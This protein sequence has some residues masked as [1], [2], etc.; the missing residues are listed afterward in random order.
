MSPENTRLPKQTADKIPSFQTPEEAAARDTLAEEAQLPMET[1]ENTPEHPSTTP[2]NRPVNMDS[3]FFGL[4]WPLGKKEWAIIIVIVCILA[5]TG[6]IL[7][8][9]SHSPQL[10][11]KHM[12]TKPIVSD[13]VASPLTGLPVPPAQAKLPITAVMIENSV[14][15]R[16][17]SGL[18]QAGV[19]FEALTEGGIT[20]FMALYQGNQSG[21]I[22]PV[23]S[24]RPYFID[25]LLP[26]NAAYAHVGG[27]QAAL[28]DISSLNVRDMN[29]FYNASYYTRISSR[30]APHNVYTSLN[31]LSSLEQSKGWN[32]S[33]FT[34]WPRKNPQPSSDPTATTINFY[35]SGPSMAVNYTYNAKADDYDRSE[36]GSAMVGA[37]S[38][39]QLA[40]KVV[41]GMVIPWTNGPLDTSGAYYTDY[42]DV[43]SGT[44][45]IFQ[46]GTVTTGTWEKPTQ[47]S[48]L[49]FIDSNG[50]PIP[51][52]AGQTWITVIG[53]SSEMNYSH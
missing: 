42:A 38:N 8:G 22:G 31:T 18:G 47:N 19:I 17:Q 46:N 33:T 53:N 45:Y 4:H 3:S 20:R 44:V 39:K 11:I 2:L 36:G 5:G 1:D 51:L 30:Q 29:Q 15:A 23:R 10:T 49:Q 41:I 48:Q 52:N 21:A 14:P 43:G 37:D 16:P 9:R 27:S 6:W 26:F 7:F 24:A 35:P 40:P 50:Q 13:T 12:A 25:W 28:S 32:T 34:S